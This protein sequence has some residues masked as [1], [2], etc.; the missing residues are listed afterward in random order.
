MYEPKKV[1]VEI[2]L[3]LSEDDAV[4]LESIGDEESLVDFL[5][6]HW[7]DIVDFQTYEQEG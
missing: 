1:T 7:M 3:E 4:E 2:T 5:R 6:D